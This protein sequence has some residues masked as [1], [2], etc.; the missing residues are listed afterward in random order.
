MKFVEK[1]LILRSYTCILILAGSVFL[2]VAPAV[3]AQDD[4]GAAD[5]DVEDEYLEEV[6]VTGSRIKRRDFSSPSP[7]T[8]VERDAFEFSGQPTMEEYLN[9][10]PQ[11]DPDL[12]RTVNN[13]GNGTASLNLRGLGAG[14][15]LILLN[16]RR[17]APSGVSSAVDV[18]NLP[19]ALMKRVEIITGGASTVYGSD[20]IAGVVN[21]ITHQDFEGLAVDGSYSITAEGDSKIYDANV[22]YG[23]QLANGRGNITLFA[24]YYERE[25]LFA[26]DRELTRVAWLDTWEGELVAGGSAAVPESV[27][28]SPRVDFG[29]G[30][31]VRT[32]WNPDGTPRAWVD[33]DDL[34]NY[35]PINYLQT[36]LVRKSIGLMSTFEVSDNF[37]A[38]FE[39]AYTQNEATLSLAE[40]PLYGVVFVN[41]DNPVLTPET[42]QL[43]E[44]QMLVAP[45]L[46]GMFLGRRMLELGPRI[47][48]YDRKYTRIVAGIRGEFIDNWDMDAWITY[49]DASESEFQRNDGSVSRVLQ[50]LLVDPATGQCF[51]PSGGCVPLDLFGA[52]RLSDEGA[53]F[54]RHD[55]FVNITNRTQT[56]AEVVVT[57]APFSLWAGPVDMA[58]G[59]GWR[60]DEGSFHADESL[61]LGDTIGYN[62]SSSVN[63]SESVWELYTEAVIPLV[64]SSASD[65]YLG[66]ELGAR[67]SDYKHAGGVWTYK[68]GLEWRPI[69]SLRFRAMFQHAVRAPN[70]RELFQ[71]QYIQS[72]WT[73]GDNGGD[74]CSALQDPA[75]N[76]IVDKCVLQ[77]LPLSE[78]G[79]FEATAFYPVDYHLGGNPSLEPE[80]SDTLTIGVVIT[81]SFAPELTLA[82][83]YFDL[84]VTDTIG[85][86]NAMLICFDPVNSGNVFCDNI[87]RDMTGNIRSITE[88]TSNR[89]LLGVEGVDTQISYVSDLPSGAALFDSNAQLTVSAIWTHYLSKRSQENIATEILECVGYFGWPCNS[90]SNSHPEDRL[91]T[92]LNYASG[93]LDIRLT[94]RWIAGMDNAAIL[95]SALYGYPDPDFAIP[96]VSSFNYFDLGFGYR[97][98]ERFNAR[99]G[100]N[101]LL[102]EEAPNMA[103]AVWSN[104]T[105]TGIYDIF[106]RTYF[107]SFGYTS[108]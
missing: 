28:F 39:A 19:R 27:V 75:G 9:Q 84:E 32:T 68:A 43:F 33:P 25:P 26:G 36:P 15:T 55:P 20:A 81:P 6:I 59:A 93:P 2:M 47:L 56:L 65:H 90:S 52:G 30:Q 35:A 31:P 100:I 74:P 40:S 17:V 94:W 103:D 54:I 87:S 89:G 23:H 86:I 57:G 61:F 71:E 21:F 13:G 46:A 108:R 34:Y 62:G 99:L 1:L 98:S 97:F 63:G 18:N 11:V 66:L 12:H 77:G 3:S 88:P 22:T 8:T 85:D 73:V 83:D 10:M 53:E 107:F 51:D 79:V 4:A 64:D 58:F 69:E 102:D 37:E 41:T 95:R 70:I 14:R 82:I 48:D 49:T 60:E 91:L 5:P 24:S 50:G 7:I 72:S 44:E 101:N 92:N 96:S 105:D 104:N 42:R 38:Y 106:G 78:I 16:G 80:S 45:G 67:Y 29:D 76:D